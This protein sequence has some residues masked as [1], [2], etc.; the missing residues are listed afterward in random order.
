MG[1]IWV[2]VSMIFLAIAA[3]VV[4]YSIEYDIVSDAEEWRLDE[5]GVCVFSDPDYLVDS[6]R[7]KKEVLAK[8]PPG[9]DFM[10]YVYEI[11]NTALSTFHR[12]VTSSK[13]IYGTRHP[14]YTCILYKYDGELLSVCPGSHATYPFVMSRIVNV[15]GPKGTVFLFDSDLLHA[16]REN[17]CRERS[18]VQYKICHREDV[19]KLRSLEGIRAYKDEACRIGW[20]AR[21]LRKLSYYFEFPVNYWLYPLMTRKEPES[22]WTGAIQKMIPLQFYNN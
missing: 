8:L 18:V 15:N 11:K 6:R 10:D 5:D 2:V 3:Y 22:T 17:G 20:D 21:V 13:H 12:D 7:F 9:Y 16:G 1:N 19:G 4:W 14:V